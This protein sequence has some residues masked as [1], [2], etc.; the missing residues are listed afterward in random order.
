MAK[1]PPTPRGEFVTLD[2]QPFY[3]IR[4]YD[5]MRPFLMNV[6]SD[7]DLWMFIASN[8]GLTAGRVDADG[9]VFPYE[10]ADKL[11]DAHHHTGPTT[12]LR[13]SRED[14]PDELWRPFEEEPREG[15]GVERNLYKSVIG[16]RVVFEEIN[17]DLGLAFRQRWA[18]ADPFGI[19]RSATL[20]NLGKRP[21]EV[22]LLD[23]LRNIL[24]WGAPLAL[25]QTSSS[26]VDAYKRADVDSATGL[27]LFSLTASIVDRPEAAESLRAN[28]VWT[29]GLDDY[30]VCLS[31]E[32]VDKFRRG[33]RPAPETLLTGRRGNYFIHA[34]AGIDPG[35]AL[36][37]HIT[38]DAGLGH[39][40]VAAL[41]QRLRDRAGLARAIED[42]LG[43]A[44]QNL[45]RIVA[46]AD[47]I[48]L[49]D[50]AETDAHHFANVL[51]NCMRGG[52][53]DRGYTIAAVDFAR[54]VAD[55]NGPVA[56]RHARWLDELPGELDVGD[57]LERASQTGDADVE[58]IAYEYLPLFFSRRHGDPSRPWNRFTIRVKDGE[59]G[60]ALT[61]EG[62]WRDIFQNWEALA[63]SF[64]GFLPGMV[65]KF[66]N[67]STVDGFNPYRVTRDGIDWEVSDPDDPWSHIGYW[68]DHQIV[69]LLRLLEAMSRAIP[70]EIEKL[71]TREIFSYANVPYRIK[72]FEDLVAD[73]RA[74]IE[75]DRALAAQID[76]R[77]AEM[78]SDGRL[79]VGDDA[80][81]HHVNLLEKLIVPALSKLSNL[82]PDAG[83]W[84]NTQRPEWNDANNALAGNGASMVTLCYLRRY[85]RF[86][87]DIVGRI[88]ASEIRVSTAVADWLDRVRIVLRDHHGVLTDAAIDDRDRRAIVTDLGTAFAAYRRTVYQ[89]GMGHGKTVDASAVVVLCRLGGEYLDHAIRA[90]RRSDGLYHAYNLLDFSSQDSLRIRHLYA[91]LEGQVAVLGSDALD[92]VEATTLLD[93]MFDSALY[94]RAQ[95]SFLLYPERTLPGFMEKNVVPE[96]AARGIPL[97]A[98]LLDAGDASLIARD[99]EGILRFHGD[100]RNAADVEGALARLAGDASQREAVR[101]DRDA[102]LALFETVF[103][104]AAFTG[105]SGTMY[106]YEGLGCIYWHMVA[107]LLLA[108]QETARAAVERGASDAAA[109]L[110]RHYYRIRSGLGYERPVA[111]YGAFPTDPYSHTPPHGGAQQPG[112]TGQVKEEI[113][114]RFGEFGVTIDD[115]SIRFEPRMLRRVEFRAGRSRYDYVDLEGGARSIDLPPVSLAFTLC[116]VPVVYRLGD[117]AAEIRVVADDGQTWTNAGHTLA[118][119]YGRMILARR[120]GITRIEVDLAKEDLFTG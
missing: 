79:V 1:K 10:T 74:T 108:V 46:S 24:P 57:L 110:I 47:G 81:V 76:D 89:A 77:V 5:A 86:L 45:R 67:A 82:V 104:H 14:G 41:R 8:G 96:P 119:K 66:V 54:F 97:L 36:E 87:T 118:S 20:T 91:M 33:E 56:R 75:Y 71:S 93:R 49:T 2:G 53:F 115:S 22:A 35:E 15:A 106:G 18:A 117:G 6:P 60:R 27:A 50:R 59:G 58:R 37:W 48:Q 16:N 68:G 70:G 21:V 25:Y 95:R 88:D 29:C 92:A 30:D 43:R 73:P 90:N 39:V 80:R 40:E 62:N 3:K 42:E 100:F 26:L 120:G 52:V 23:G 107:K 69:Y 116:Q 51:F 105:R 114:T 109:R 94:S 13:V 9:A 63:F 11:Y 44:D 7:S 34:T 85:L 55:R 98:E 113:L 32:A 99:A 38:V 65:A 28:T 72:P 84:M 4:D 64:P 31:P 61:Y 17:T 83:I 19:V 12:W 111:E 101:R 102:V 112:M 103:D 78:G